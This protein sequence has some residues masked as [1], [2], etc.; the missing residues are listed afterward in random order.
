MFLN[1]KNNSCEIQNNVYFA[2]KKLFEETFL[3]Q[4]KTLIFYYFDVLQTMAHI[5]KYLF[6]R[7]I[8]FLNPA[9]GI[10]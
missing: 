2:K 9:Y 6:N 7:I 5:E 1:K 4:K 8:F 3:F 10:Y